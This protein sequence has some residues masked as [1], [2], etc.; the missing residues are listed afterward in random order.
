MLLTLFAF[1]L[2]NKITNV[3]GNIFTMARQKIQS[4]SAVEETVEVAE[5][6]ADESAQQMEVEAE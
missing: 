4:L 2:Y 5:E 3:K 6:E 1:F